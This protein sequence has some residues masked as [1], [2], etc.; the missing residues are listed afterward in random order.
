MRRS[1]SLSLMKQVV[2]L[3]ET[4]SVSCR[5]FDRLRGL[6]FHF[7]ILSFCPTFTVLLFK[8]FHFLRSLTLQPYFFEIELSVSPF[9][10]V[11][12]LTVGAGCFPL[13][14]DLLPLLFT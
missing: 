11:C 4:P 6:I 10:T 9:F 5:P 12:V 1:R 13:L 7:L 3:V 14:L 2:E 8:L